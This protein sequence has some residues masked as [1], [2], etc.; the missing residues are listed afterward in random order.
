MEDF[1]KRYSFQKRHAEAVRIKKKYP[2]RVPVIVEKSKGS[3]IVDIDKHKYL[4]PRKLTIGQLVY[5]IRNRI[6]LAP[7]KGIFVFINN[8]LPPTASLISQV[9]KE[10]AD[11]DLF[12]YVLYSGESTFGA[13]FCNQ[14]ICSL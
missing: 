1:K 12:L 5:V 10:H 4:V 9:Y 14:E 6:K 2:D 3:D 11:L 8:T 13:T 7:D